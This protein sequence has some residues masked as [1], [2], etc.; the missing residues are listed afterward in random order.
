MLNAASSLLPVWP[1]WAKPRTVPFA[2]RTEVRPE[3][4]LYYFGTFNPVHNGHLAV[5]RAALSQYPFERLVFVPVFKAPHKNSKTIASFAERYDMLRLATS[6]N[7]AMTVSDIE[8]QMAVLY[9]ERLSYSIHTVEE[10]LRR[11][12]GQKQLSFLIG[13]DEFVA[14]PQWHQPRKLLEK[15][16]FVVSPRNGKRIPRTLLIEGERLKP[17]RRTLKMPNLTE[18]ATEVRNRVAQGQS[19]DHLVPRPVAQYIAVRQLYRNA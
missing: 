19:I 6:G 4:T 5:A 14:L 7:P 17:D 8:K 18:S 15:L 13:L 9:P 3:K 16:R 2:G 12:P 10:L 11:N 1:F